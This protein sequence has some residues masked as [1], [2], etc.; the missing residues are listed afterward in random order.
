MRRT[1]RPGRVH[2]QDQPA[3]AEVL[4]RLRIGAHQQL[5][6]VGG[7]R[8]A[9]PDLVAV[10]HVVVPVAPRGGA[11]GGQVGAGR[12]L[13]E[14]L[15][16]GLL[17]SQ[18]PWQVRGLLLRRAFDHQRRPR[19]QQADEIGEVER[20]LHPRA[21]LGEQ[22]LLGQGRAAAAVLA[23]PVQARVARVEQPSLPAGI[24]LALG[25]VSR[26][27]R[28]GLSLQG[29]RFVQPAAQLV[30]EALVFGGV[31]QIQVQPPP[32]GAGQGCRVRRAP[33]QSV[34]VPA[35]R[36]RSVSRGTEAHWPGPETPSSAPS[37][38]G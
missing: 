31:A 3:Q 29:H 34:G 2:R 23:R 6:V 20:R 24:V 21:L 9:G 12:G 30:A 8:H 25:F 14:A 37:T 18:D 27:R 13:R 19:V 16:P 32:R 10:D 11:Q 36:A 38:G 17:A 33:R 22:E 15:A 1:S 5:R 7:G 28:R 35:G 4:G 26:F